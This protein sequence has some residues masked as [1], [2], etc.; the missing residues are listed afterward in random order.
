[1]IDGRNVLDQPNSNYIK[2]SNNIRKIAI[3]QGD[4]FKT[5]FLLD[6]TYFKKKNKKKN[7]IELDLSK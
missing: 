7:L 4:N 5:C 3:D 6:F 2:T 1:M